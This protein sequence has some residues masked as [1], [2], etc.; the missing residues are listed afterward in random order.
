M[1]SA[2]EAIAITL[3]EVTTVASGPVTVD[4]VT[5]IPDSLGGVVVGVVSEDTS[6]SGIMM[7]DSMLMNMY[8]VW[9]GGKCRRIKI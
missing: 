3:S 5:S 8:E 9:Y 7:G 4:I 6:D 1:V 2:D